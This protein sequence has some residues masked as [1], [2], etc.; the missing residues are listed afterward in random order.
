MKGK[1]YETKKNVRI[2]SVFI[3]FVFCLFLVV[4]QIFAQTNTKNKDPNNVVV[5]ANMSIK[6]RDAA[7]VRERINN[8]V[9]TEKRQRAAKD[10]TAQRLGGK[11]G[12]AISGAP[13][14]MQTNNLTTTL[15]VSMNGFALTG[16]PGPIQTTDANMPNPN[17]HPDYFGGVTPNWAYTPPIRKFVDTLPGLGSANAN[18][19]GQFLPVAVPDT[20]TYPGCDYYEI[21]LRRYTEKMHSDLPPT[22]LQGYVQVNNGTD[23]ATGQNTLAPAAIHYLGPIIVAH[24]DR[25]VRIK[26]TNKL[27]TGTAGDLF[28]PTDT[29]VMGAG[30]GPYMVMP[31]DANRVGNTGPT[32]TITT[33]NP[34]N[35]Q[36]GERIILDGFEPVAYNGMFTVGTVPTTKSFT[37]TLQSDPGGPATTMGMIEENYTQNRSIIHLHGGLTPWVSDGTPHQWITPA[38]EIT[39]YPKGASQENVPDMNYP[40]DNSMTFYYNNQQTSRLLW[41][42]DHAFGITRLNVYVGEVSA[43]LITDQV[44][45]DLVNGTNVSGVNP[46]GTKLLPDIGIPLVIQDKSFVD[47]N[48]ITQTDPT[49]G[50]GSVPGFAHT[51]DLWYPHV[52]MPN[53]NPNVLDGINPMGRWD[54]GPWFWPPWPSSVPPITNPDGTVAPGYPDLS[55]TM[56]TMFDTQT[57]NGTAYPSLAVDPCSYRF[58]ILN[59]DNDRFLNLQLYVASSIVGPITVTNGGSGYT[60][61]PNVTITRGA[62]DTTGYGATAE[63][64]I[65]ANGTVTSIEQVTVG[66]GYTVDPIVTIDPPTSGTTATASAKV[67]LDPTEVGMVPATLGAAKFPAAWKEQASGMTPD[68]LDSRPGGVPDPCTIGPSMIQIGTEGG[69]LPAP[70]VIQNTPIGFDQDRRSITVLN[71][72]E[73]SL[74]LGTAERADV[75]IDFSQFAGKT[76]LLYNDAPAPAPASDVRLDYYTGHPDYS[77]IGGDTATYPGY[78]PNTRTVMQ[79]NVAAARSDGQPITP[80]DLKALVSV[81]KQDP[82]ATPPTPGVFATSQDPILVPQDG[83]NTAYDANFPNGTTAYE[84]IQSTNLVFKP[85]DLTQPNKL[86]PTDVNIINNPKAIAEEFENWYGRMQG[87]LGVEM[88]FTNGQNQ[89][90]I[91]YDYMDPATEIIDD[92]ITIAPVDPNGHDGTQ[93]WKITH[94]G[95]DTHPVHFHLFNVQLINRVDWA[96]VVKPPEQNELGWKETIR[97]NPLEDCIVAL[98]PSAPKQEF[99]IPDSIR[100][101]DPTM[102]PGWTGFKQVDPNG[103]PITPLLT[104]TIVNYGWEY[105]WHC[106]ILSHEEMDMMRPIIFNVARSLPSDPSPL[107]VIG[108]S[109]AILNWIDGTPAGVAGTLGNPANEVGFR[110]ERAENGGAFVP[111]ANSPANTS[112]YMDNTISALTAYAYKVIAYNAAGESPSNL[113]TLA[114]LPGA[115]QNVTAVAGNSQATVSFTPPAFD[116]YSTITGYTVT[117]SPGNITASGTTSSITVMGLTNGTPY[118]FTVT[119]TNGIG[120]GPASA[121]SNIV[122]PSGTA[123]EVIVDNLDPNTSSVGTWAA[124]GA[125]GFW[126][127]DSVWSR[128]SGASFT[129]NASLVPG[130]AYAVYEWHTQWPSR[131]TAVP[132]QIRDGA[133]ILGTVNVNQKLNTS[134]WHLLG[135]YTFTNGSAS[136]TVQVAPGATSSQWSTNADAV[137]FVPITLQSLEITGPATVNENSVTNYG[138]IAHFSGGFS[139][140]VEPQVWGVDVA[141]AT[142][143]SIGELTALSVNADTP[144]V[145]S[146]QY[147]LGGVTANSTFNVTILNS[148]TVPTEVIVDNLDAT[149]SSVGTWAASGAAGFWGTNSVWSR[150]SGASFTFTGNIIP[151]TTYQVYEW[152]TTWP[153]RYTAVPHQIMDGAAILGTVN[154]NQKLNASQWNL[155]GTYTFTNSMASVTIQVAPGATGTQWSTNAD[156][157]RLVPVP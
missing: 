131:Y 86:S 65:D 149:T 115:P 157:I 73:H 3:L 119:A 22:L 15:P 104:N 30:M 89:T 60:E 113:A 59:G 50:W 120:T 71:M 38:G 94:N 35:L 5:K 74:L 154:V 147:T 64:Y 129:F 90:T 84:R 80:Y 140:T 144:A 32:V 155:L 103:N 136:V 143:S 118:T 148:G 139:L 116:G 42:H 17:G 106:H 114:G 34:H 98:R 152:H 6:S 92:S 101:Y 58:R 53:Q 47:A 97:M 75:L 66:S 109:I 85:L 29:T 133:T 72:K 145:I 23:P 43:Y 19:L 107:T 69:F 81:F 117:S 21:E 83:Y 48:T 4:N 7:A 39:Q 122:T 36:V 125:P 82:A 138:A 70:V 52:Y 123:S 126:A 54:Y 141:Q 134:Q 16:I 8:R 14:L 2:I 1:I 99:G 62:G 31:T 77:D 61:A 87:Y 100:Y 91:W 67:Y 49:W 37:V 124:S 45:Q 20:I 78:A 27:P 130:T 108:P 41:Y 102:P 55:M 128:S 25:P 96:G 63:A 135:T 150:S 44:E 105:M 10:L 88:P 79:F 121:P 68:I 156:A 13:N 28:I 132:H 110:I 127:T 151:G 51:G 12:V 142:I 24:K 137:R 18:N 9:T 40:G 93:L 146:A 11:S 76:I 112:S 33:M 57:V 111:L 95:V 46:S 56:E 153:S 26:Y